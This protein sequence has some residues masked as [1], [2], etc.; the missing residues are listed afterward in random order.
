MG[1]DGLSVLQH[2]CCARTNNTDRTVKSCGPGI[3]VLM[4]CRRASVAHRQ[5]QESRSLGRARIT[6][7]PFAQG[8]PVVS[9]RTCG[10]AACFLVA[11]GPRVRPAPGLPCALCAQE[12]DSTQITRAVRVARTRMHALRGDARMQLH[13]RCHHPRR[14]MILYAAASQSIT[15]VCGYWVVGSSRATTSECWR[16]GARWV[17]CLKRGVRNF[18]VP[19]SGAAGGTARSLLHWVSARLW[20]ASGAIYPRGLIDPLGNC[21]WPGPWIRTY[22]AHLLS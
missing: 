20:R 9:A 15:A 16:L 5:G 19:P 14:R 21:P 8:R 1:C 22:G 12:G 13:V 17:G 4:P 6:R 11:R 3:P 2:A 18:G 7:N 10:S